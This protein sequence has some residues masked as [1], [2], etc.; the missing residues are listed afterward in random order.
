[1]KRIA[2]LTSGNAPVSDE[3]AKMLNSGNRYRVGNVP[4]ELVMAEEEVLVNALQTENV[5]ILLV[6]SCDREFSPEFP[7]HVMKIEE[8]ESAVDAI[9][10]L[11]KEVPDYQ[12]EHKWANTLHE[13][14][15]ENRLTPPP[16]NGVASPSPAPVPPAM[17][18]VAE[19]GNQNHTQQQPM[20]K[21]YMVWAVL[22]TI[23]FSMLPGIVAIIYSTL[24]TS[25][26]FNGNYE[27]ALKASRNVEIWTIVS[28]VVGVITSTLYLPMMLM[29]AL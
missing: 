27:G 1:M 2:I 11:M 4:E 7:I 5:D 19:K 13:N 29:S 6:E 22:A 9:R 28:I 23:F 20:P 3:M 8:G 25:R 14:F 15:D 24:V 21:T 18:H 12:P 17:N 10:R 16:V 26:Y